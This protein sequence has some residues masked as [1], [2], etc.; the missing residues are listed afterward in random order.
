MAAFDFAIKEGTS[1]RIKL[2]AL[3]A[4]GAPMDFTSSTVELMVKT[5][6]SD[7]A[8]SLDFSLAVDG[9]GVG[10]S[11]PADR[12]FLGQPNPADL[13]G[14]LTDTAASSGYIT[15]RFA[16]ADTTPLATTA[17]KAHVWEARVTT[18]SADT[19]T[20]G[21][22]AIEVEDSIFDN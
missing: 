5:K 15:V 20:L 22:G 6:S 11:T 13:D 7:A 14:A 19:Y 3:D 4:N 17:N 12:M 10:V 21:F 16:P 8:A 1:K 2:Y 18:A 9:V